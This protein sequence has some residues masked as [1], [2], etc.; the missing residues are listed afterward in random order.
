[1][2]T[3]IYSTQIPHTKM[4]IQQ[5]FP[6]KTNFTTIFLFVLVT[7]KCKNKKCIL[8]FLMAVKNL[9]CSVNLLHPRLTE[10]VFMCRL[11]PLNHN[12]IEYTGRL[13]SNTKSCVP[14]LTPVSLSTRPKVKIAF[15][16][17]LTLYWYLYCMQSFL[18]SIFQD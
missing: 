7:H 8:L 12:L 2:L 13:C 9:L 17:Q 10:T 3:Y 11:R 14:F 18:T 5:F 4:Y 15:N 1:M 6:P 16:G